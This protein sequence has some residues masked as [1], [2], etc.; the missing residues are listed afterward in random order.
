M[1]GTIIKRGNKWT[2]V[3]D[4]GRD[5]ATGKRIRR[6]HSGYPTK[7]EAQS[8][9]TEILAQLQTGTYVPPSK[10]TLAEYLLDQW[11]PAKAAT[12]RPNT[13][14]TYRTYATAHIL[15]TMGARRLQQITG[16][17][18]TS[19]YHELLERLSPKTVR[20]VHGV[21]HRA[22]ADA[23][24]WDLLTRNPAD[25]ADPPSV[26]PPEILVWDRKEIRRFLAEVERH[27]MYAAWVLAASTGA[28]RSELLGLRWR[29]VNLDEGRLAIADTLVLVGNEPVLRT[30]ETKTARSRRVIS[31]DRGSV[32]AL[33]AHRRCQLEERMKAGEV[34]VDRDLVFCDEL[35]GPYNPTTFTRQ[36]RAQAKAADLPWIG[37]HGLRHSWAT[38][39]LSSG[40]HPKIVQERLGH[41]SI[42]ITLDRY[43][44]VVEGMDRDAA[45]TVAA[46]L[47]G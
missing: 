44:H 8:A 36:T 11:L 19:L 38:M 40:V 43:S 27:R 7:K 24:R 41:S 5:P 42:S 32:D 22:M 10:I 15:P 46:H 30:A 3:V 45:E 18:I 21:L 2:V 12:I 17:E 29:N 39:A 9:R 1:T 34:Y 37:L 35:G 23:V 31:L 4:A 28:R 16:A 26:K 25:A 14:A 13:Q 6:W 33:R 47:F 20:N